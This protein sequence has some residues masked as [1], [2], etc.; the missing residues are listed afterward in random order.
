VIYISLG[1]VFND[2]PAFCRLCFDAFADLP[3]RVVLALGS[4]TDR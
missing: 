2:R 3:H 1:T 4:A